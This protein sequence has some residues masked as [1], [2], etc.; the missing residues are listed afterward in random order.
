MGGTM[1]HV[2]SG[3]GWQTIFTLVNAGT[4]AANAT[5]NYFA[6]DGS[7]LSL[8]LSFPQTGRV[9]TQSSVSQTILPG[10]TLVFVTQGQNSGNSVTGS[11][12]LSTAGNVGG[13]AIFQS[14]TAGQEA[15]VPL[16]SGGANSYTLAFDNTGGLSTGVALANS[17]GKPAAIPATLRDDTGAALATTTIQLPANGHS[18]QMLPSLFPAAANIRGTLEFDAPA[19]GQIGALGIRAT[20]AG[21][22]TTIPALAN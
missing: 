17:S 15:V 12:Q 9:A 14:T 21:A 16:A 11:A 4:T 3:G 19:G 13:F 20:P 22:F 6:D 10:A 1:A 5:L 18:S 7:A 8:P 2:A